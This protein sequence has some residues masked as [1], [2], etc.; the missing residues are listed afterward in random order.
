MRELPGMQFHR[1]KAAHDRLLRRVILF[2]WLWVLCIPVE[3]VAQDAAKSRLPSADS[4]LLLEEVTIEAYQVAGRQYLLPGNISRLGGEALAA[5]DGLRLAGLLNTLPGVTLQS[6]TLATGRMV[7]RGMGSRTPYNTNRIRAYLDGIPLT[8]SDGISSPEDLD[9]AALGRVEVIR[10]PSSALYGSGLGG[11]I[12]LYTPVYQS[13]T[14]IVSLQYGSFGTGNLRLSGNL[15]GE[16][17][18]LWSS[19]SHLHSDGFRENDLYRRSSLI[20]SGRWRG[21]GYLLSAT[22]LAIAMKGGIPSSLGKSL[23]EAS[24]ASA[25]PSWKAAGGYQQFTKVLA[26]VTLAA[27]LTEKATGR[28]TLYGKLNDDYEKRPFNNLDDGAGGAGIRGRI[29]HHGRKSDWIAGGE[30]SAERY[31]WLLDK[32]ELLLNKNRETRR[33]WQL[34]GMLYYRPASRLTLS[35]AGAVSQTH[36]TL[37]DLFPANGDQSGNRHFPPVFSPRAGVSWQPAKAVT[38]FASAGQ[39][40]SLPSP[41]ETLLPDG[42]VNR[43]IRHEE[44]YQYELGTRVEEGEGRS[45]LEAALYRINLTDLLVTK[46]VSEELFTGI[47]AGKSRHH[48]VELAAGTRLFSFPL[49]PG[50]LSARSAITVSENKFV[51]FTDDGENY[52]GKHLP[53]IPKT[54]FNLQMGWTPLPFLEG[55]IA[56]SRT[57]SQ[58]LDDGN[59]LKHPGYFLAN[60]KVTARI[61]SGK[62]R[63]LRIYAGMDN[64]TDT[65]YASMVV[66]NALATGSAEPRYYYPGQPR[67]IFMGVVIAF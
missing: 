35:L 58:F 23:F 14:G 55:E 42:D 26:G 3:L 34:F 61:A 49:F 47:N 8:G 12:A 56:L 50:E 1:W 4:T 63:I 57:G 43:E 19:F 60:L 11:S 9:F 53:G 52:D 37:D 7:I 15:H 13:D 29:T 24:P 46:R 66:V 67:N 18:Q 22:M 38:L 17:G 40:Y 25:A 6:G 64:V 41:E 59:S 48:G 20:T 28:V 21:K 44:G 62:G 10:G 65:R 54:S 5:G 51:E 36:Y 32:E 45:F 30:W 31:A 39:G 27:P 16:K 2:A 33:Q